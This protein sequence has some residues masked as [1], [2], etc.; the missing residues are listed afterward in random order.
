MSAISKLSK[1]ESDGVSLLNLRENQHP[2]TLGFQGG[3]IAT[4][5]LT[6]FRLSISRLL[7]PTANFWT[8]YIT[9]RDTSDNPEEAMLPPSTLRG[10]R[11]SIF[12]VLFEEFDEFSPVST[13]LDG[14]LF[15]SPT[16]FRFRV[17]NPS[18]TW[19]NFEN[20]YG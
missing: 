20:G 12:A 15:G 11:G 19:S 7:P 1:E 13:E 3:I 9:S 16:R 6:V 2:L 5:T 10:N 14:I 4:C 8:Q 18:R 17:W